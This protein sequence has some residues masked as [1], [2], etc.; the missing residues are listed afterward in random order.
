[1]FKTINVALLLL[2]LTACS[3]EENTKQ[4]ESKKAE[5]VTEVSNKI[6]T[7]KSHVIQKSG[8]TESNRTETIEKPM[9]KVTK[10]ALF[11]L[12]TLEG[13]T[14]HVN[15]T[16]GGLIFEE[17]KNRAVL[18]IFFGHRCPPCIK[19]IPALIAMQNKKYNDLEIIAIEVQRL[20]EKRLKEFQSDKGINYN[21]LS[22]EKHFDFIDFI[23]KQANWGGSIPFLA[24]FDTK[25][26]VQLIHA[27]G[28]DK[29]GFE[30]IYRDLTGKSKP[31][32]K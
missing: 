12:T 31:T 17:F 9:T 13:K 24:A 5:V 2:L 27:G 1:M 16:Q 20:N 3:A 30:G 7:K 32:K 8:V 29:A 21:L 19:E 15:E 4:T 14:I 11:T 25:G 18:L 10:E 28:I 26:K 23:G 6:E 22:S